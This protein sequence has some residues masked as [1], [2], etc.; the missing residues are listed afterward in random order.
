MEYFKNSN[1]NSIKKIAIYFLIIIIWKRKFHS[2]HSILIFQ[3]KEISQ[4]SFANAAFRTIFVRNFNRIILGK[5]IV[6][7][8]LKSIIPGFFI[9]GFSLLF[10]GFQI[11]DSSLVGG[12]AGGSGCVCAFP[13]YCRQFYCYLTLFGLIFF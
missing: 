9:I 5:K 4:K 13:S 2:E 6:W 7:L 1:S 11:N 8:N 12:C 3:K 10:Y